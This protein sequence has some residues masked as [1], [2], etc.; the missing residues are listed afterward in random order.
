MPVQAPSELGRVVSALSREF[1]SYITK[2]NLTTFSF[3]LRP[4]PLL[5]SH[6]LMIMALAGSKLFTPLQL[7]AITL[8]HRIIMAPMTRIR[9]D[10]DGVHHEVSGS[11][12]AFFVILN[13]HSIHASQ[14]AVE[15]YSQRATHGGLLIS[16]GTFIS[17]EAGGVR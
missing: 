4:P 16:E 17:K 15:Y 10:E 12:P 11:I 5:N 7:G 3:Q 9:A 2:L 14:I 1:G 8:S 6:S 13:L